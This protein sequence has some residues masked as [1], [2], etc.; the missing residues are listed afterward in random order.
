MGL[1]TVGLKLIDQLWTSDEERQAA[2]IKL[3]EAENAGKLAELDAAFRLNLA[4]ISANQEEAKSGRA[5]WRNNA[6]TLAVWSLGYA[7]LGQPLLTWGVTVAGHP[8]WGP[9]IIPIEGALSMLLGMLG[10]AGV[11]AFDLQKG[12]RI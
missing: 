7:W 3:L 6:G 1:A 10:L 11:R 4:Q 9:P 2:K 8:E 12:S 5:G